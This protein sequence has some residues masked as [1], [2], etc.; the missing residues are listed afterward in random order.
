MCNESKTIT[1]VFKNISLL[2]T[3]EEVKSD[4]NKW[5]QQHRNLRNKIKEPC[6]RCNIA[7]YF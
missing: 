5:K 2:T 3:K 6:P 4:F 1:Q 7:R